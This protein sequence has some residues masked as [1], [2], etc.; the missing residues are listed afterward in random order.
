MK[1]RIVKIS[2]DDLIVDPQGQ[3]EMISAVC[4]RENPM[5]ITGICQ[6]GEVLLLA[7]EKQPGEGDVEYIFSPFKSV[8]IDE[9]I[10]EISTRFYSGF[11]LVGGFDVKLDKWGLFEIRK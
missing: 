7:L 10:S 6:V 9:I 3:S 11:S 5:K 8:N 2:I 1:N 4:L